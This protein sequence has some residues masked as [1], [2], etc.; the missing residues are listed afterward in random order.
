MA[1]NSGR[2]GWATLHHLMI[3]SNKHQYGNDLHQC[4]I[5]MVCLD[6]DKQVKEQ[7]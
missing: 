2:W 1:F 7:P 3:V 4:I 5:H 6:Q